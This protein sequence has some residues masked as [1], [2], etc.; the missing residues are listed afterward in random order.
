VYELVSPLK[1]FFPLLVKKGVFLSA[2]PL[3]NSLHFCFVF[4]CTTALVTVMGKEGVH[5]GTFNKKSYEFTLY[6]RRCD[7]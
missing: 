2:S 1:C 7:V 6:L 4:L 5:E 3:N